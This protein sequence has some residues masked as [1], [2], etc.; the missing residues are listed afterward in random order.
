[1]DPYAYILYA[2]LMLGLQV[3]LDMWG[4]M[5]DFVEWKDF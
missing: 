3:S 4:E 1:M 5:E 2:E